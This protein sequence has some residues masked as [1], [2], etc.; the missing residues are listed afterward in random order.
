MNRDE[1]EFLS[2]ISD[3]MI[4]PRHEFDRNI[5]FLRECV[6]LAICNTPSS[7][8]SVVVFLL[9]QVIKPLCNIFHQVY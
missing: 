6:S 3:M 7:L 2:L 1:K 9:L 8:N 5:D 4:M